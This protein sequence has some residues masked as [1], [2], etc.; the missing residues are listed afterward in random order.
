[1]EQ[2][3][4]SVGVFDDYQRGDLLFLTG[5]DEDITGFWPAVRPGNVPGS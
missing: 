3:Y 2:V 4:R 5:D 1:M